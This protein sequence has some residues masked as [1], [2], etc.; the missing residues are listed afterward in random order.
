MGKVQDNL[1]LLLLLLLLLL[2]IL[3]LLLSLFYIITFRIL[4]NN[5]VS[6]HCVV[7]IIN[8]LNIKLPSIVLLVTL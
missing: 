1:C 3:L 6:W 7:V 5:I 4:C 2:L 8:I